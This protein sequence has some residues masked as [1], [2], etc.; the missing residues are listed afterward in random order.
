MIMTVLRVYDKHKVTFTVFY[1]SRH[2]YFG[3]SLVCADVIMHVFIYP[4]PQ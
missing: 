1:A 3:D 4:H 2:N